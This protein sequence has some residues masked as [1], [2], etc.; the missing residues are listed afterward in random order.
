MSRPNKQGIDYFPLDCHLDEK[1]QLIEAK[2]GVLGFGIIIKLLQEI[3]KGGY[4]LCMTEDRMLLFKNK[5]NVDI[6]L[7]NDVINDSI[8]W[9][10]FDQE[11]FHKYKILTSK[12]V[13]KRY[14]EATKRRKEVVF[15]EDF[16]IDKKI[17]S[18]YPEHVNVVINKENV[19]INPQAE[20]V[21]DNSVSTETHK[22]D[23]I[24]SQSKVKY[25]KKEKIQKKKKTETNLKKCLSEK[26]S[27]LGFEQ[28]ENKIIEFFDYRMSLQAKDRYKTPKGINGLFRDLQGCQKAG[29]DIEDCLERAM[30]REWLTPN[31]EYF[32]NLKNGNGRPAKAGEETYNE[33]MRR[34]FPNMRSEV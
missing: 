34:K 26:I 1:I 16:I 30:E 29:F 8:K 33:R 31:P 13:Q 19:D 24:N 3:Y 9:N 17:L 27:E 6:N 2:H 25:T 28:H 7:I 10:F 18:V 5:V 21:N 12:G 20:D 4:Y 32:N 14:V 23:D 11:K 15:I 22:N